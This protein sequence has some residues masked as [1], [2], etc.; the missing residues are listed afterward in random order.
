LGKMK[1]NVLPVLFVWRVVK[2]MCQALST[3]KPFSALP[4]FYP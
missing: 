3:M 2:V 4:A 1:F